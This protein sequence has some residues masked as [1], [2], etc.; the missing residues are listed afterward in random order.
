MKQNNLPII[1]GGF[2]RSGTSLLRRLLDAHSHIHCGPE[3]KFFKDFYGDYLHD[4]LRHV[5][6]FETLTSLNLTLDELLPIFGGAFID[7]H[8]LAAQKSGKVR[9]A[10]KNPENVLYLEQWDHI[11]PD[12][13]VFIHVVRHPLDT[14]ASLLE[15]G[16]H[17][18]VPN[19]F[20]D[21]VKLLKSFMDAGAQYEMLHP[22]KSFQIQYEKL[23]SEPNVV[24][25]SLFNWLGE[26]FEPQVLHNYNQAERMFGIED[27][28]VANTDRVHVK[29]VGR[30][31]ADLNTAQVETVRSVL[32]ASFM[33]YSI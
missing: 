19:N 12:G 16:F 28:K 25:E 31:Q 24:L 13:F 22:E 20:E 30:W 18:A 5:R 26:D 11:L 3:V 9:W 1:V 14:I 7:A 15:I 17:K 4:E 33:G 29:S 8:E 10:D 32:G 6:L 2:Y 23:V 21:K 27:P